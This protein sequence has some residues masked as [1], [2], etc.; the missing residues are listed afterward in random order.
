MRAS[1]SAAAGQGTCRRLVCALILYLRGSQLVNLY[2]LVLVSVCCIAW[3]TRPGQRPRLIALDV[4]PWLCIAGFVVS[5]GVP[6]VVFAWAA[7]PLTYFSIKYN[8]LESL[9]TPQ[10]RAE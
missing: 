5:E 7:V 6:A 2:A 10:V 9:P 1:R 8:H 3:M 4:L